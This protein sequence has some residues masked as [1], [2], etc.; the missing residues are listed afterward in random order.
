LETEHQV[1]CLNCGYNTHTRERI[2]PKKTFATTGGDLFLWLL[3]GILAA[4]GV[5]LSI[6][7]LLIFWLLFP[8]WEKENAEETWAAFTG[9]WARLWGSVFVLF[10]MFFCGRFAVIRLIFDRKPPEK[11]KKK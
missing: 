11:E 3:P 5:L 4:I 8:K 1:I 10:F 6:G 7:I 9:L 2:E